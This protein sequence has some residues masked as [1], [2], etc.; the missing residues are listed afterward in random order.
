MNMK[1]LVLKDNYSIYQF[2]NGSAIPD[3]VYS[4]EFYSITKTKDELSV[5]TLQIHSH[6]DTYI[7][8]RDW[9]ILKIIGPLD[10]SLIGVISE[11]SDILKNASIS[12]FAI[13]TYE[14]DYILLKQID[15]GNGIHAL[16]E[17]GHNILL[18]E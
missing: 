15:M 8:S 5:V 4:S 14:T 13:S 7:S 6:E 9:R 1:I 16:K 17:M 3:W 10:L 12:I 18:E 2:P 11:I